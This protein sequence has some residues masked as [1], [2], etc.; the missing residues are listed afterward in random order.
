LAF[1]ASADGMAVQ[2]ERQMREYCHVQLKGVCL[3]LEV[4]T[5]AAV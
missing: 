2:V 4:G 3:D 1:L 5:N